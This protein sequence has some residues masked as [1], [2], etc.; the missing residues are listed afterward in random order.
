M[1]C[2]FRDPIHGMINLNEGELEIVNS[3]PFQRLRYIRQLGTSYLVYHGAEHTRFGHSIGVMHLVGKAMDILKKKQPEPMDDFEYERLKQIVKIVALVHDIG[4]APFSHVGEESGLFPE[5]K[6]FDGEVTSGHEVYSRLIVSEFLKDI[7][8]KNECFAKMN[9]KI[10]DVLSFMKGTITNPKYFFAKELISG[11]IDMDRMDYL[12]RDSYYCGVKYGEYDL[13]RLLDT[14]TICCPQ[15]GIWQ[16]GIES[17]GVQAVEEFVFSRYWMFIQV[18][19]HKTRRIL[20]YY[21]VEFL[22]ESLRGGKYPEELSEYLELTDNHI[23]ELVRGRSG[24]NKWAKS[25]LQRNCMSE[26]FVS[27]PH[28]LDKKDDNDYHKLGWI[29]DQLRK[30][31]PVDEEPWNYYIDQAKTSSAK[32][33]ISPSTLLSDESEEDGEEEEIPLYAIPVKDKHTEKID[34]VQSYSLPINSLS[35]K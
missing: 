8:E 2:Q 27:T 32:Y 24:K 25:I 14:L 1:A 4:H 22:K 11:Q 15:E 29:D 26:V 21:L 12:L 18:Y 10:V 31:F 7:I 5:L 13:H 19:F 16:L 3:A 17:D 28:Q 33:Q 30:K 34:S 35:D 9:I 20:D 23:L 6:D